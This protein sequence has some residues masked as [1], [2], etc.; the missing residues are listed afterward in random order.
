MIF[1]QGAILFAKAN[2]HELA[3]GRTSANPTFGYVKNPYDLA[4]IPGGSSGG[5]AAA[6]AARIVPLGFG[7]DTGGSVRMPAHF[8]GI[9]GLRPS[10]P[11]T[12]KPYPVEGIVPRALAF[13]VPGP[14]ARDVADIALV[15]SAITHQVELAPA[16]LR[17]TRIGIPR[18]YFWETLDGDVAKIMEASLDKL[19]R[20]GAVFVDVDFVDLAN[21]AL[22]VSAVLRPEGFRADLAEFLSH[23][24][25]G[26]SVKGAIAGI[27]SKAVRKQY[28]DAHDHRPSRE[29]VEKA[30]ASMD[31]LGTQYQDAFRQQSIVAIAYP[32]V[33]IP[34]P[35]LPTEGD[36]LP[37][38]FEISGRQY[39][40][41]VS[42]RNPF[43]AAVYRAP[44]LSIPAGLTSDGLPA[45]LE[46][47][48][49]PGQDD[50]LLRL[51]MAVEAVLGPLPPPTF[52]N[53]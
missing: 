45:G 16:D 28:E 12:N 21:T 47:D 4:R 6:L 40:D 35:L 17:G 37:S 23:E 2:M 29:D 32:P 33:P 43:V 38:T 53:G 18:S 31:A 3:A 42:T 14:T 24:Y 34:A 49:L 41:S 44:G 50:Q 9:A 52:R 5:T 22:I 48:G 39:P 8:C 27:A 15:H 26:M 13:D 36:E 30:R 19:R 25:A 10:N 51:G 20:A 7:S 11:R 46:I 1:S